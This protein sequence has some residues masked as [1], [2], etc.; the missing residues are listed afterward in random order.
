M[1]NMQ[2]Q[3]NAAIHHGKGE[4]LISQPVHCMW[5]AEYGDRGVVDQLGA[6]V[7]KPPLKKL[8]D[9]QCYRR[10]GPKKK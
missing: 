8:Y 7:E 9:K 1:C 6:E 5:A 2:M 10:R 4:Q 3:C